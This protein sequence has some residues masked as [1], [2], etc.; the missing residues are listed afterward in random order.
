MLNNQIIDHTK[1]NKKESEGKNQTIASPLFT[2]NT[3]YQ[4][5]KPWPKQNYSKKTK[6]KNNYQNLKC[7]LKKK[8]AW[9]LKQLQSNKTT[10]SKK[11]NTKIN[12]KKKLKTQIY[13]HKTQNKIVGISLK[14]PKKLNKQK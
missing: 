2:R 4:S 13:S 12:L 11:F 9:V 14:I 1:H 6:I 10:P 5:L 3:Q 8:S 7:S